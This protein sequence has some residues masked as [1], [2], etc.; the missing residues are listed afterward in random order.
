MLFGLSKS[1]THR[2]LKAELKR[3][4]SEHLETC[5]N[6]ENWEKSDI[7]ATWPNHIGI[8]DCTEVIIYAWHRNAFSKKKACYTLKYQVVVNIKTG[9]ALQIYG[10]FKGSVHDSTV[11]K[12]SGVG[13]WLL[14]RGVRLLGDKAYVGCPGITATKKKTSGNEN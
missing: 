1:Q 5:V 2:V 7:P 12:K 9:K 14:Q 6:I 3:L 13:H 11:F 4:E 10:P 8:I